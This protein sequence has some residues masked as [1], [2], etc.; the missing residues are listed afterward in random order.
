[1]RIR[2]HSQILAVLLSALGGLLSCVG[3]I[4]DPERYG[5]GV[6][7]PSDFD[8]DRLFRESCSGG[9]C[10]G[11]DGAPAAELDLVSEGAIN[12]MIHAPSTI[13]EWMDLIVPGDP[14]NSLLYLKLMEPPALCGEPMPPI[15]YLTLAEIRCFRDLIEGLAE[16]DAG[17]EDGLDPE[18]PAE[19]DEGSGDARDARFGSDAGDVWAGG[20]S[21]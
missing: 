18:G 14:E 4:P 20:S 19:D 21:G 10:H 17:D 5:D 15:G 8:F 7:C 12:R 1:M 13:C 2:D 16:R 11:D 3:T 6:F 9:A